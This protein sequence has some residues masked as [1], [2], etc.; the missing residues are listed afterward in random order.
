MGQFG[1]E[2]I[3]VRDQIRETAFEFRVIE[4][5]RIEPKIGGGERGGR[6]FHTR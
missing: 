2:P 3:A 1:S 5:N 4:G 6:F